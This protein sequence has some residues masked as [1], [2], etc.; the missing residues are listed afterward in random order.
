[1]IRG[2][3]KAEQLCVCGNEGKAEATAYLF[4]QKSPRNFLREKEKGY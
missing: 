2:K 3:E 4:S 1:M